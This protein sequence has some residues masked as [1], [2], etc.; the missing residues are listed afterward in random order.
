VVALL[1]GC[2]LFD[3]YDGPTVTHH[4]NH[5]ST[6]RIGWELS[7]PDGKEV[8]D[9]ESGSFS[10]PDAKSCIIEY[11]GGKLEIILDQNRIKAGTVLTDGSGVL[12][13]EVYGQKARKVRVVITKDYWDEY[14]RSFTDYHG[15]EHK[16]Y[17]YQRRI[18]G[19]FEIEL[20]DSTVRK[21]FFYSLEDDNIEPET[22]DN[23]C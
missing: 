15:W 22:Y 5:S 13:A 11:A 19:G 2:C 17:T 16:T 14:C 3:P 18:G 9:S 10:C 21:G 4:Y 1:Q 23:E 6:D 12:G 8:V 7:G 20:P